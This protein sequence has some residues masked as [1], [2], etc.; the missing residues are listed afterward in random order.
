MHRHAM[1]RRWRLGRAV[2]TVAAIVVAASTWM[3]IAAIDAPTA[4]AGGSVN[5][6]LRNATT[7]TI[8]S[9]CPSTTESYWNFV[10]APTL[11]NAITSMTLNLGS[12]G[13]PVF[14]GA[15]L[16]PKA[17]L[18]ANVFVAVPAGASLTD[19]QTAGS[20]ASISYSSTP[21]L[22]LVLASV[23]EPTSILINT[24]S[25]V[26]ASANPTPILTNVTYTAAVSASPTGGTVSFTDNGAAIATCTSLPLTGADASCA[27]T[28]A[29][30]G[31]HTIVA[32]YAGYT[33]GVETFG[34]S[35][36]PPLSEI[37]TPTACP[38][39]IGCNLHGVNLTNANLAGLDLT[40]ANLSGAILTG[41]DLTGADLAGANL[42]GANLTNADLDGAIASASTN[43]NNATWANTTCPNGTNSDNDT[44]TCVMNL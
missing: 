1:A 39:L 13:T 31:A 44:G 41:A 9:D 11:G 24:T 22:T 27:L 32:S 3:G 21:P 12:N 14:S 30:P 33:S 6:A 37:V 17:G 19:L 38:T 35:T 25:A 26:S 10:V 8:A 20:S 34:E 18:G 5:L 15:A 4:V 42:R 23:C 40:N 16:I 29:Q 2:A 28:Y 7:S 36:S 43:F